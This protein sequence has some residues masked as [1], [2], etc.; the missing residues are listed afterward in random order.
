MRF[1]PRRRCL[2]LFLCASIGACNQGGPDPVLDDDQTIPTSGQTTGA[3]PD[4]AALAAQYCQSCHLL[5]DPSMLPKRIWRDAIIPRMGARLG[6]HHAGYDYDSEISSGNSERERAIIQAANVYPAEPL[7]TSAQWNALTDYLITN[8]P[9]ELAPPEN[10]PPINSDL[11]I[12]RAA[13]WPFSREE[14]TTVSVHID[15]VTRRVLVGDML[16]QSVSVLDST[17]LLQQELQLGR[18]PVGIRLENESLWITTI[19]SMSPSDLPAGA[20]LVAEQALNGYRIFPDSLLLEDLQ[21]PSY[22]SFADLNGDDIEDIVMSEFGQHL[23]RLAWYEGTEDP[24]QYVR[25]NLMSEP[26]SITSHVRDIDGNGLPDVAAVFG[27]SRE[28]VHLFFNRGQGRFE[29]S[30]A[31]PLPPTYGSSHF[32]LYDFNSD[33]YLDILATNGD[34]G[35]YEA[36]LKPYHGVRIYLNDQQNQYT[37][38]YFFPQNGAYKALAEDFDADG[39][40]DIVSISMYADYENRPEE[41][42]V[43]LQNQGDL[44][45]EAFSIPEVSLGRWLTMD[46]GDVDGDGDEDVVLGSFF[47]AVTPVPEEYARRWSDSTMP[48][49]YLENQSR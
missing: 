17:G 44:Q 41:G 49:L 25:H 30:Y 48:V 38:A 26:G 2:I 22:A 33:G 37:E 39:D 35:D 27:Q 18:V 7:L 3:D 14:P 6:M 34:N 1:H 40:L 46:T 5:V 42:F 28:G 9:E 4:G 20:L 13:P 19:G 36:V 16:R 8:A 12:L 15:E 47:A 24:R 23:G 32:G 43:Y 11:G 29:H 10:L 21:R 31:V 45:F